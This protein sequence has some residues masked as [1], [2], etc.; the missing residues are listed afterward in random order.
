MNKQDIIDYV[1]ETPENTNPV[2]LNQ[3]IDE[4]GGDGSNIK[5]ANVK[6]NGNSEITIRLKCFTLDGCIDNKLCSFDG[7]TYK[8]PM[9][10]VNDPEHP[11]LPYGQ[12][13]LLS[14]TG[15][16]QLNISIIGSADSEE[17]QD[18]ETGEYN[19]VIM[20]SGDCTITIS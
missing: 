4:V 6:L 8:I 17:G 19:Y 5:I 18:V 20:I 3:M 14:Y 16:N 15:E 12:D 11:E 1:M 13:G 7:T 10:I 9:Y 2:I